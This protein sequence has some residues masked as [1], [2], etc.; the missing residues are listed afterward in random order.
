MKTL[1]VLTAVAAWPFFQAA[2]EVAE[3]PH[4]EYLELHA[5][6]L[7]TGGCTAS[8]Q[9]TLGGRSLVRVWN[10]EAGDLAGLTV[11]VLETAG[12]NLSLPGSSAESTMVYLPEQASGAQR[13]ALLLW[14][15]GNEVAV[16]GFRVVPVSYW[17]DGPV[18]S[19]R[20]GEGIGFS[21]R[22]IEACDA[23]S[24]GEQLWYSPRGKIGA[25]TVLVNERSHVEEP[26]LKLSWKDN[27]SKSVF[28][29]RFGVPDQGGFTLTALP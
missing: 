8:A 24:C 12:E 20:A 15:K 21:T 11:V 6:D 14:L 29:G 25:F 13:D 16:T 2:A 17:R 10:F 5:C 28:F 1:S 7:F 18:V 27:S 23:G 4:G 22:A 26:A 19:V 3:I 9:I